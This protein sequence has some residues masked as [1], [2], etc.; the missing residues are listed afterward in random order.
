MG[1][2][3][4][5]D[6]PATPTEE[7]PVLR[8]RRS[9]SRKLPFG[10]SVRIEHELEV[11]R[12]GIRLVGALFLAFLVLKLTHV[13][14]WSWRWVTVPLW[15]GAALVAGVIVMIIGSEYVDRLHAWRRRRAYL[16]RR[17]NASR[18]ERPI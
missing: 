11:R 1:I 5:P 15:G 17:R 4:D 3:G 7:P 6:L 12:S 10:Q 13:V 9:W 8:Y 2:N 14:D 16:R 18:R